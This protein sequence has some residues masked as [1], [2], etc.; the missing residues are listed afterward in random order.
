MNRVWDTSKYVSPK[1]LVTLCQMKGIQD[2]NVK[3]VK[4]KILSLGGVIHFFGSDV[5]QERKKNNPGTP[6]EWPKSDSN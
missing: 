6:S 2:H 5:R 3:K 4:F 1:S